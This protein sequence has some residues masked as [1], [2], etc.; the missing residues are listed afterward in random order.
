MSHISLVE[1]IKAH[2][3][4]CLLLFF[5]F[6]HKEAIL[7]HASLPSLRQIFQIFRWFFCTLSIEIHADLMESWN[8]KYCKYAKE[9]LNLNKLVKFWHKI[10]NHYVTRCCCGEVCK[11]LR[12]LFDQFDGCSFTCFLLSANPISKMCHALSI[13]WQVLTC[14]VHRDPFGVGFQKKFHLF[15]GG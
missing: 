6:Y 1:N 11:R 3:S 4:R 7:I 13:V 8:E 12:F 14:C 15:P 10:W 9:Y 2:T 5:F